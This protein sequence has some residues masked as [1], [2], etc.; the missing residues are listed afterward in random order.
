MSTKNGDVY[1]IA[2][3]YPR[4]CVFDD[5]RGWNTDPYLGPSEFYLEYGDFDFC[6][7][8]PAS[9]L[10]VAGGEL[11]NP[12]EVLTVEQI[13]RLSLASKSDKTI[14]IRTD[15]EINDAASRPKGKDQLTW[16]FSLKN[17]RDVA[18]ASSK[19]FIWDAAKINLPSGKTSIAMSVYPV[20]SAGSSAW[21]RSTEYTKGSVE[22]YSK[23]W[24]EYPYP[25]AV[26]VASNVG[27]MEYPG[28]VFCGASATNESLFGVTDHEFGHTWFPMIVGS[29]ERR[30]GWMDEG[31]NSFINT[32]SDDDFNNGEYNV[33]TTSGEEA[34]FSMFRL[35]SEKVFSTPDALIERNI[36][37]ALYYKPAFA[38]EMLRSHILGEDRFDFAFRTYIAR[39]A[40]KHPTPWDFFR[41]MEDVSGEDLAWFWKA[42][43]INNYKFDQAIVSVVNDTEKGAM[44]TI[45]NM[46]QMAMPVLITY[47]TKYGKKGSMKLP[48]EIWNNTIDF[49]FRIPVKEELKTVYIDELKQMPDINFA[50]NKWSSTP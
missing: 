2:Q 18:W 32:L 45:A 17:A 9:H 12:S 13:K 20:E 23:R 25:V 27:G 19:A 4:M 5:V 8:A 29:N 38:L 1:T 47:E 44:V 40:F 43:F 46:E 39:W 24:Y 31:F 34:S 3:W 41:T 21:G 11:L 22:N 15:K 42:W 48:V 49:S 14:M 10:V 35:N 37:M 33:P 30:Y 50:N 16:K 28:I 6:I 36:G 7:T 26:N